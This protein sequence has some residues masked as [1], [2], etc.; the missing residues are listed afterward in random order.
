M[1]CRNF[2]HIECHIKGDK[3]KH[4]IRRDEIYLESNLDKFKEEHGV[5]DEDSAKKIKTVYQKKLSDLKFSNAMELNT[6]NS[7]REYERHE[8]L[9]KRKPE[10]NHSYSSDHDTQNLRYGKYRKSRDQEHR[11]QRNY[12][13]S[14]NRGEV[15]RYNNSGDHHGY[16]NS[17]PQ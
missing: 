1:T 5:E 4:L 14:R 8:N 10:G 7:F 16:H 17:R 3:I 6:V 2:G 11:E 13:D 12:D 9:S 15:K